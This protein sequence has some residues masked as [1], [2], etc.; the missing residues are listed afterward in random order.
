MSIPTPSW[1]S[2]KLVG[3]QV[4]KS[5]V[6]GSYLRRSR[7]GIKRLVYTLH[8]KPGQLDTT[9]ANELIA[10]F[11][12]SKASAQKFAW[13]PWNSSTAIFV[14]FAEDD[15]SLDVAT[16]VAFG[17]TVKLVKEPV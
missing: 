17:A 1:T 9:R 2:S 15:L 16:L 3:Y 5:P 7:N 10:Q 6:L 11:N 4:S 12:T 8:Y 14:R 13:T